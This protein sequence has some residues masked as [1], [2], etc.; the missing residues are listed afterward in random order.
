MSKSNLQFA[1]FNLRSKTLIRIIE[2]KI[3]ENKELGKPTKKLE[4]QLKQLQQG[5]IPQSKKT[6]SL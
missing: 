5:K 1:N 6:T 3:K 2:K 4:Q